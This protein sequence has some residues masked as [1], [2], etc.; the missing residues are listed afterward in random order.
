MRVTAEHEVDAACVC[1]GAVIVGG[2]L[3]AHIPSEMRDAN[4]EVALLDVP[5]IVGPA[6]SLD[7]RIEILHPLAVMVEDKSFERR[8]QSEESYL[9]P[10]A[11]DYGIWFHYTFKHCASE[12]V[13]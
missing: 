3:L 4:H 7:S 10:V 2:S 13:V 11:L 6:L 1:Y 5:Q 8:A 9:H 12:V